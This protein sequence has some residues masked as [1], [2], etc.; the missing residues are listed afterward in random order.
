MREQVRDQEVADLAG[1]RVELVVGEVAQVTRGR[2]RLE[3]AHGEESRREAGVQAS[4]G[5]RT[6]TRRVTARG[7]DGGLV[8]LPIQTRPSCSRTPVTMW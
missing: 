8:R 1:E 7:R 4:T 3:V 2:D 6:A 5:E